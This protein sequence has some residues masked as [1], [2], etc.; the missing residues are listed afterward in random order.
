MAQDFLAFI[1]EVSDL[2]IGVHSENLWQ[3]DVREVV[4]VVLNLVDR[5]VNWAIV[6]TAG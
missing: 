3:V 6:V 1:L 2:S 4:D 5:L